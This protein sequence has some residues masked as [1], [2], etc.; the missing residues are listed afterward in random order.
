MSK[1]YRIITPN[2]VNISRDDIFYRDK[3]NDIINYLKVMLTNNEESIIQQYIEPK[4]KLLINISPGTDIIDF[5]KLISKNYYLDFLLL[6]YEQVLKN[7]D[8]FYD[9]FSHILK[10]IIEEKKIINDKD[11][12]IERS[13]KL[14][15]ENKISRLL[16]I[17][18]HELSTNLLEEKQLLKTYLISQKNSDNNIN[19]IDQGI[20]LVW[21]NKNVHEIKENSRDIFQVFDMYVKVPILNRIERETIL[22]NFSEKNPKIVFN[23]DKIVEFTHNWEIKDITQLLKVAIFKH[24]LNA[25]LNDKSNEITDII[26]D[27]IESDEFI[28]S[29]LTK[30][31]DKKNNSTEINKDRDVNRSFNSIEKIIN[32]IQNEP[33]SEFMLNQLY[34]NAVSNNYN[35]LL[36]I[37]DKLEKNAILEENDKKI[38]ARYPFILNDSPTKARI[39]LEKAKKR[40]DNIIRAFEKKHA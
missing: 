38:I 8:N 31:N 7:Q 36:I 24:F 26:I 5:L 1:Y 3:F 22:R 40:I 25:D 13:G 11:E 28:P 35:E 30:D 19:Y 12:D 17:N 14:K 29:I 39:N 20:I 10:L 6:D 23:I 2:E 18:Q 33:M 27:L 16:L 4:G 34:E 37:I 9:N 15:R 32:E 21:I